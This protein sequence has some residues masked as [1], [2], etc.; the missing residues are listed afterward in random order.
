MR[1]G[2][3]QDT[4]TGDRGKIRRSEP[5]HHSEKFEAIR[6]WRATIPLEDRYR[7]VVRLAA[8]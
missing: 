6:A 4:T 5:P 3:Q 2:L 8:T 1:A 7:H